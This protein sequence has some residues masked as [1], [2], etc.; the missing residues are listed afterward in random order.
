[1]PEKKSQQNESKINKSYLNYAA[2]F[3]TRIWARRFFLER[4]RAKGKIGASK[5]PCVK[6]SAAQKG[7]VLWEARA[8]PPGPMTVA[9]CNGGTMI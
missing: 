8:P 2:R 9:I 4:I 5:I 6:L 1:M 3:C 7:A